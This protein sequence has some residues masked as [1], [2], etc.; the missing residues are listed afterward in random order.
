MDVTN[1]IGITKACKSLKPFVMNKKNASNNLDKIYVADNHAYASDKF[2][3]VCLDINYEGTPM[4]VEPDMTNVSENGAFPD[5]TRVIDKAKGIGG[6]T[7]CI[8]GNF[9]TEWKRI[10]AYCMTVTK[11]GKHAW[12]ILQDSKLYIF[13][14]NKTVQSCFILSHTSNK[15]TEHAGIC[16]SSSHLYKIANM[17]N[18]LKAEEVI[19]HLNDSLNKDGAMMCIESPGVCFAV[20]AINNS[21]IE[22]NMDE[23][24]ATYTISLMNEVLIGH[25]ES[26]EETREDTVDENLSFL[27]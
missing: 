4:T 26:Q 27:D 21:Y 20:S 5:I 19:L 15:P 23:Y 7:V 12:L 18:E 3:A 10:F 9:M 24:E 2:M 8:K 1:V 13:A 6:M 11:N 22:S 16:V 14:G 17:L 25:S